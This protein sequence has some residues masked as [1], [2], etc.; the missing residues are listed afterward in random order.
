VVLLAHRAA[1]SA[2]HF[3]AK[4]ACCK[5]VCGVLRGVACVRWLVVAGVVMA[6]GAAGAQ[7][8]VDGAI[9]GHVSA[10]CGPYPHRCVAGDV[11]VH[12]TSPD[13]GVERDVDADSAG[14]FFLLR[15]PPG[16]YE[17]R[18]SIWRVGI[19]MM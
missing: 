3:K 18:G 4:P 7:G 17:V 16:E 5:R 14:D 8:P 11:R 6:G 19:W 1:A 12:V 9:R 10:V 13:Q 15:L 2:A